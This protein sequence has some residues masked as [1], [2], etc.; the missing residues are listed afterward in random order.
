MMS[1]EERLQG[2]IENL[3]LLE[4]HI[5]LHWLR[6]K[7]VP[8]PEEIKTLCGE[9]QKAV[10]ELRDIHQIAKVFKKL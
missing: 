5:D 2:V 4:K 1:G 9:L 8:T 7:Q 6:I 3:H 10:R